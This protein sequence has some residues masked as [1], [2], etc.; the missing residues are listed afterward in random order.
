MVTKKKISPWDNNQVHGTETF[1]RMT[2]KSMEQNFPYDDNQVYGNRIFRKTTTKSTE[3]EFFVRQQPSLR[4]QNLSY[5][6]TT[7]TNFFIRQ[8]PSLWKQNL[9]WGD[10]Q[11][12]GGRMFH[13][14]T[15]RSMKSKYFT[16]QQ[17]SLWNQNISHDNNQ[18][19]E[20]RI[21]QA[22]T[23]KSTEMESPVKQSS[24]WKLLIMCSLVDLGCTSTNW[25]HPLT[26]MCQRETQWQT[27]P[28][29]CKF[30]PLRP[31]WSSFCWGSSLWWFSIH[32]R[33]IHREAMWNTPPCMGRYQGWSW[34]WSTGAAWTK[35]EKEGTW[36]WIWESTTMR[37][38]LTPRW[39][40]R[41]S[42]MKV[43]GAW[44]PTARGSHT[45]RGWCAAL[46]PLDTAD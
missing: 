40:H 45:W 35:E 1:H 23:T 27:N 2:T 29:S 14:T 24:P 37:A 12:Y 10:N 20:I 21:F 31:D 18:V 30:L 43:R 39:T 19:C 15:T 13:M 42:L 6:K 25:C 33:T 11:V 5:R 26:I 44:L 3:T 28:H 34:N 9:P 17:P 7:E 46:M 16:W 41:L 38:C 4:K 22:T 36:S 8:Y 32:G